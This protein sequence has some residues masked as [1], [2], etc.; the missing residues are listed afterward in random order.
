MVNLTK[1][2][3]RGG[4]ICPHYRVFAYMRIRMLSFCDFSYS[5][6]INFDWVDNSKYR[7]KNTGWN[8]VNSSV[9]QKSWIVQFHVSEMKRKRKDIVIC[10]G[11]SKDRWVEKI[12]L[13]K[14]THLCLSQNR[15][16]S[17][18]KLFFLWQIRT[19]IC[20]Y[21][22][23]EMYSDFWHPRIHP[24]CLNRAPYLRILV[25]LYCD[26]RYFNFDIQEDLETFILT[27]PNF[28]VISS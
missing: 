5:H 9:F 2:Y 19:F 10:A 24:N 21:W 26:Y 15:A 22:D 25:C 3:F 13:L 20:L 12:L 1:P 11:C 7:T 4:G 28:I 8:R 18:T 23:W 17:P 6:Y 27:R 16:N 14:E